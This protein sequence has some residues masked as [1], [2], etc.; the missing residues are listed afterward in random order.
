MTLKNDGRI[1][2]KDKKKVHKK[3]RP[4]KCICGEKIDIDL[5]LEVED[6]DYCDTKRDSIYAYCPVCSLQHKVEL[7]K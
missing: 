5:C 4:L 1:S 7:K 6:F 3:Y 2:N